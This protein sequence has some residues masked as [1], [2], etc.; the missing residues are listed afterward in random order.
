VVLAAPAS[1]NIEAT[2]ADTGSPVTNVA[3][4]ANSTLLGSAT[5]SPFG[6]TASNL[7]ANAYALTAIATAAGLSTTSAVVNFTVVDPVVVSNFSPAVSGGKFSFNY[8]VNPGLT[9]IIQS[10]SNLVNWVPI[11]TNVPSSSPASFTDGSG[12]GNQLFYE[13]LRPPNPE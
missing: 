10:S 13:V 7:V 11:A 8:S 6:I 9:Y 4:F 5:D 12:L 3:F 2:A 1:L